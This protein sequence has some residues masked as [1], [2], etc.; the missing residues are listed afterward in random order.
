MTTKE[1]LYK[2]ALKRELKA[3]YEE[4][5][6]SIECLCCGD[7]ASKLGRPL[8]HYRRCPT[9]QLERILAI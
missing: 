4:S 5:K 7:Y 9:R 1:R 6:H 3:K 8:N 2:E